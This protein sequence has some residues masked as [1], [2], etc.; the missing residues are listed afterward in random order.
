MN[1]L[2][3]GCCDEQHACQYSGFGGEKASATK[4]GSYTERSEADDDRNETRG[5]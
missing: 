3:S 2:E 5:R 1:V 4:N